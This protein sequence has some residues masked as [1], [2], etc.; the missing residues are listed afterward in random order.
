[1]LQ[2]PFTEEDIKNVFVES[3][4]HPDLCRRLFYII[5]TVAPSMSNMSLS[6]I[7]AKYYTEIKLI[8]KTP[9]KDVWSAI[10]SKSKSDINC[11]SILFSNRLDTV[12]EPTK[13]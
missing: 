10:K 2:I 3:D 11:M 9:D 5:Q 12:N 13:G 7:T 6:I 8:E 1:M 4:K